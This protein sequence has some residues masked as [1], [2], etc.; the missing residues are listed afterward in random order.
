M[1]DTCAESY[2]YHMYFIS[3]V[4]L[5]LFMTRNTAFHVA[6][7]LLS[8]GVYLRAVHVTSIYA[9]IARVYFTRSGAVRCLS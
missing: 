9:V 8:P 1:K 5:I 2:T 7:V 6:Q 3:N 4:T